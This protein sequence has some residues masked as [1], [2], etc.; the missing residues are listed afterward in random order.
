MEHDIN[1]C[2]IYK[3][4]AKM[5][6]FLKLKTFKLYNYHT[7][8]LLESPAIMFKIR[9]RPGIFSTVPNKGTLRKKFIATGRKPLE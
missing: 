5:L 8:V 2:F 1:D 4:E 3:F 6:I 9:L 7:V